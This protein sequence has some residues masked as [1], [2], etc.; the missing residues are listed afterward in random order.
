M[1]SC[2]ISFIE[3]KKRKTLIPP[4]RTLTAVATFSPFDNHN[5]RR[6]LRLLCL[7]RASLFVRVNQADSHLSAALSASSSPSTAW[8]RPEVIDELHWS[9]VVGF[10]IARAVRLRQAC[11][12]ASPSISRHR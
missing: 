1:G 3:K 4:P 9:W 8:L 10:V 11:R 6:R 2:V 5:K 7:Y 12:R